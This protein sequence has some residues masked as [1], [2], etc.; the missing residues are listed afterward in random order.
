M[1]KKVRV[2]SLPKAQ[3]GF[4][5]LPAPNVLRPDYL[6]T[7]Q[8]NNP[9]PPFGNTPTSGPIS[10]DVYS[11]INNTS[12]DFNVG[13][14]AFNL[15]TSPS[16]YA[17]VY[18]GDPN[19]TGSFNVGMPEF[20]ETKKGVPSVFN[21]TVNPFNNPLSL[22]PKNTKLESGILSTKDAIRK[23]YTDQIPEDTRK[24]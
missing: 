3:Y 6:A 19:T 11:G 12:G 24:A 9:Y 4:N 2:K 17:D 18:Q 5:N 14:P 8:K 7:W 15:N 1:K 21:N 13:M 23:S 20:V 16:F 10:A 22:Y